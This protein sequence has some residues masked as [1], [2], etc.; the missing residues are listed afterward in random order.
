M[1]VGHG[2]LALFFV[3]LKHGSSDEPSNRHAHETADPE[4]I[5]DIP[6]HRT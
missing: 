1:F 3:L 5:E 2:V 6:A 4:T